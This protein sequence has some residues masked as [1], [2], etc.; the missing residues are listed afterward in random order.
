MNLLRIPLRGP[1]FL[2]DFLLFRVPNT[3]LFFFGFFTG[4]LL[5]WPPSSAFFPSSSKRLRSSL[6]GE[7]C[8]LSSLLSS[9]SWLA[10]SA[11][12]SGLSLELPP[13]RLLLWL[14]LLLRLTD[15]FW[16]A[17]KSCA[18]DA[19]CSFP[20]LRLCAA[21]SAVLFSYRPL[22]SEADPLS[23][24]RGRRFCCGCR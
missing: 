18:S 10:L 7:Y 13:R 3:L 2:F 11:L 23:G 21:A 6:S 4:P 24:V 15:F 8:E 14:R 17:F 5:A 1:P 16:P 20:V 9:P 22:V 12:F 19:V